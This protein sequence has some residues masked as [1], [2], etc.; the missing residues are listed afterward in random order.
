MGVRISLPL[1]YFTAYYLIGRLRIYRKETMSQ[2]NVKVPEGR[3]EALKNYTALIILLASII[4]YYIYGE[5]HA[6]LRV[7]GMLVGVGVSIFVFSRSAKGRGW[8]KYLSNTKKEVSLVVWPTRQETI[9]MTL[10]VFVA[11]IIMSIFLWLV[12]MFFLWGVQVLTGQG[13]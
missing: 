12:D 5:A 2:K 9:Q 13:G 10:I 4:G 6:V 3:F 8:F 1:P 7:L 11:V